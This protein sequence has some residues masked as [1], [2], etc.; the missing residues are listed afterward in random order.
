MPDQKPL[1][2]EIP[3]NVSIVVTEKNNKPCVE[4][5]KTTTDRDT[6]KRIISCAFHEIPIIVI[7]KFNN[8]YHA[9]ASLGE[10]G[11]IY[12]KK[13]QYFFTF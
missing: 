10:K 5:R 2:N 9:L 11:I 4:L 1:P 12:R 8:K 3:F 7:P 6:I 13:E